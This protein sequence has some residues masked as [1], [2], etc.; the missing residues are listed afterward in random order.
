MKFPS[1]V[2]FRRCRM[3]FRLAVAAWSALLSAT[4]PAASAPPPL[5]LGE[6]IT[7]HGTPISLKAPPKGLVVREAIGLLTAE[8]LDGQVVYRAEGKDHLLE[9]RATI[10]PGGDYL[11]MTPIGDGYAN[12]QGKKMNTLVAFRSSD[13]GRTWQGPT[14]AFNIDY[15]QHGFVPLIPR[16][17]KRIYAFGT[18]PI[19]PLWDW[20]HGHQE[21]APIGYRWSDD[22][23]RTWSEVKLIAPLN[24]PA[25][26]GMSA[27]RMTETSSGAWLI[28]SHAADWSVKPLSTRQYILRSEDQG[29]SWMVLP[30]AQ[31][32]GWFAPA[33]NRMDEGRPI[34]L[35][36][37]KV[38]FV[39]RT[40]EGHLWMAHSEDD[41]K[42]WTQPAPSPLVHPDAPP[43]IFLLSDGKTLVAFHHNRH[44]QTVYQG[45]SGKMEGQKDRSEIWVAT[46][47]DEG[48]TWSEPRFLLANA[49]LPDLPTSW[50][51]YQCSYL[52]C[53]V[54]GDTLHL[55]MPHRWQQALHL[56]IKEAALGELPTAGDLAAGR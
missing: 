47:A 26:K 19:P 41:G 40:P 5:P 28:G 43:M 24:D 32:N 15:S 35:G 55:F 53:F 52:D 17:S 36:G 23:G 48:R 6:E 14:P 4:L 7:V 51:N 31:P 46:S 22:D 9:T 1:A 12:G 49:A 10:T 27:T 21:D 18:Q 38:L 50:F 54:D 34:S 33:F 39:A 3:A 29:N 16:G 37:G 25:F 42:T 13:K 11:L 30:G 44:S 20:A 45:L 8:A 56:T 2:G